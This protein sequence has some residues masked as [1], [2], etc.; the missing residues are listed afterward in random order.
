VAVPPPPGRNPFA[1]PPVSDY[2]P[3]KT[4][5]DCIE[6]VDWLKLINRSITPF[7]DLISEVP[8]LDRSSIRIPEELPRAWLHLLL[9]LAFL[10]KDMQ[11]FDEQMVICN[12]L[13]ALGMKKVIQKMSD[14]RLSKYTVFPPSE[15][16]SLVTFQLLQDVKGSTLDISEVYL[17]YL[18]SLVSQPTEIYTDC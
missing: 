11:V 12:D 15:F 9:S 2:Y 13:I 8:T 4:D 7:R 10:A 14:V 6:L 18:K 5:R 17:E 3:D 1:P 16:A